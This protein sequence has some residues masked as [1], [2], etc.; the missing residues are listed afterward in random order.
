M[1]GAVW[2]M[3]HV[4]E[5]CFADNVK[6]GGWLVKLK[7]LIPSY[8][9]SLIENAA[10]C[11]QVWAA[12]A[13][14]LD[15]DNITLLSEPIVEFTGDSLNFACGEA[16]KCGNFLSRLRRCNRHE[17]HGESSG[18]WMRWRRRKSAAMAAVAS[19]LRSGFFSCA[20]SKRRPRLISM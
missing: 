2:I 15:I 9:Q 19:L 16:P 11:Q 3:I 12:T 17:T 18:G 14:V 4:I 20:I 5:R 10:L 13:A 1:Q 8:G 6:N 7:D